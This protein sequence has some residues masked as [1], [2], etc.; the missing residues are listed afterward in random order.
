MH[1]DAIFGQQLDITAKAP[2]PER[3][4]ALKT[5]SYTVQGPLA[6][7]AL[8]ASARPS[9]LEL[10]ARFARPAGIAFQLRDDLLGAFADPETTGKPRGS[11]L[12]AGKSTLL[13]K[14]GLS[15]ARGRERAQL[16]RVLGN[17]RAR[18]ADLEQALSVLEQS[19]ARAAVE[20]R[21]DEL[22]RAARSELD[23]RAI[24]REG[25]ELLAGAVQALAERPL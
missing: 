24:T 14:L 8:L 17:A 6:V 20:R 5:A 12:S 18:K 1:N 2:D 21:I 4:Y 10:L 13:V 16:Q 9:L 19:G 23:S 11:D 15:R 25:R 3:V 7:G 22:A